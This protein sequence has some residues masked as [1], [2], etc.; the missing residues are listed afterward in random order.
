AADRLVTPRG[1]GAATR[2]VQASWS[3]GTWTQ[4]P[5]PAPT[6][7][8]DAFTPVPLGDQLGDQSLPFPAV[9]PLQSRFY[10]SAEYL[11]WWLKGEHIPPL[12][13]AGSASDLVPGALGQP[14]TAVLFGDTSINGGVRSGARFRVG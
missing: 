2:T 13:T 9:A 7:A 12:V 5:P 6:P 3:P 8:P 10:A 11:L 1:L 4:A 14:G